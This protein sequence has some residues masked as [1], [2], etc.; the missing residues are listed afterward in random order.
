MRNFIILSFI[1]LAISIF[2][3][4][5]VSEYNLFSFEDRQY[6]VAFFL[7]KQYQPKSGVE[8]E[9]IGEEN[10]NSS[11]LIMHFVRENPQAVITARFESGLRTP[12]SL[13]RRNLIEHFLYEIR[14]FF[15]VRYR[16][17]YRSEFLETRK[18][19]NREVIE[20]IFHYTIKDTLPVM[21]RLFIIPFDDDTAYYFMLQVYEKDFEKVKEDLDVVAETI[22]LS[23]PARD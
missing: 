9:G 22:T 20:H 16:E 21:T 10:R 17:G 1:L 11:K 8:K 19:K 12:T 13:L 6:G 7:P 2:V 14:Q 18:I 4:S 5:R 23:G 3:S 15:P